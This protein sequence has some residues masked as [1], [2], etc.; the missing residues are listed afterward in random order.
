MGVQRAIEAYEEVVEGS[1][2]RGEMASQGPT[3]RLLHTWYQPLLEAIV[4]EQ[5]LVRSCPM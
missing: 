2:Q 4:R 3:Q 5:N 1:T